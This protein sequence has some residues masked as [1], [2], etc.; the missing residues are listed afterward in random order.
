MHSMQNLWLGLGA[1]LF[2][3]FLV[4]GWFGGEIY[5]QAP[6]IPEEVVTADGRTLFTQA[7]ILDGLVA[8]IR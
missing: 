8:S 7:D 1:V 6:P 3:T 2:G 5:R 4:L